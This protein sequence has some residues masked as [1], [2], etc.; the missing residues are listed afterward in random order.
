MIGKLSKLFVGVAA[1]VSLAACQTT[2]EMLAEDGAAKLTGWE[3]H[4]TLDDT[5]RAWAS[6]NGMSYYAPD[7]TYLWKMN[8]GEGGDGT[9]MVN[10]DDQMCFTVAAWNSGNTECYTMYKKSDGTIVSVD[11]GGKLYPLGAFQKGNKL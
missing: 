4:S 9:W 8:S 3:I 2:T 1:M 11:D 7:G 5:T 6:G 10:E